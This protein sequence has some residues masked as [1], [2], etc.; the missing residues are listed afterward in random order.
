[1][2][3]YADKFGVV[4]A[5]DPREPLPKRTKPVEKKVERPERSTSVKLG[6]LLSVALKGAGKVRVQ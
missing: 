6:K 1:M 5:A 3:D 2:S 4:K